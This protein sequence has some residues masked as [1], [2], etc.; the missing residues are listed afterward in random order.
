V[1]APADRVGGP[2]AL[3]DASG[4]AA[5]LRDHIRRNGW[6]EAQVSGDSMRPTL[7]AGDIVRLQAPG[8]VRRGDI[9]AFERSGGLL[10]HRVV[11]RT[12]DGVVCRGDNRMA[13]DG[14]TTLDEIIGR[15]VSVR[16]REG[17]SPRRL[18]GGT[19]GCALASASYAGVTRGR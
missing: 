8:R 17:R 5:R 14:L 11:A 18:A 16:M 3:A 7:G 4:R 9:V 13:D 12:P 10:V 1:A 19:R 15:A 2:G 6:V